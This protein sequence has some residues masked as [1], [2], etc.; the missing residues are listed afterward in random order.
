MTYIHRIEDHNFTA[1]REVLPLLIELF[2]PEKVIDV[3]CGIGTW[4]KV[5]ENLGVNNVIGIDGEYLDMEL[6]TILPDKLIKQN[7]EETINFKQKFDLLLCLEVAEHLS[8]Q[9]AEGF[10]KDLTELSDVIVFSAAI[11]GQ[12]GQDHINEQYPDYWV[13]LFKKNNFLAYDIIRPKIWNNSLIDWWYRQNIIVFIKNKSTPF[14]TKEKF[15]C[16]EIVKPLISQELFETILN[17]KESILNDYNAILSGRKNL[18]FYVMIL[19]R[20]LKVKIKIL[21]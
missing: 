10:V 19:F 7:L 3:G 21:G 11:P 14:K 2:N 12:G 16:T 6:L 17:E 1:A 15:Y 4:L 20:F 18:K 9:R 5:F 8:S 13:G